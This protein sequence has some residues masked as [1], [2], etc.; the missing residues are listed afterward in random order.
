[1]VSP[2]EHMKRNRGLVCFWLFLGL[3]LLGVMTTTRVSAHNVEA[4]Y[5]QLMPWKKPHFARVLAMGYAELGHDLDVSHAEMQTIAGNSC[6]VGNMVAFEVDRQYAYDIDEPVDLTITYAPEFTTSPLVVLWNKNGGLGRGEMRINPEPGAAMRRVTVTLDRA[7]F[8]KF[9]T[10]GVDIAIE[11]PDDKVG[12][13]PDGKVALCDIE[14]SRSG[15]TKSPSAFGSVHLDVKDAATGK[16]VPARVGLYDATGR[17]PMPS[18]R[19]LLVERFADRVRLLTVD[20]RAF[21]P[22][23]SRVAFYVKGSYE[24]KLPTGTY[25][26]IVTRGPEF[27]VYHSHFD[28][29]EGQAT[30]VSVALER[31]ANLPSR[32]WFSGDDHIHLARDEN[33][34]TTVWTQVAAEDVHVGNLLQM[35]NIKGTYF[36]QPAWGKAGRFEQ[37][38]Y[39]IASGQEDPRTGH[40]GHTI[41]H[42]LQHPI[43]LSQDTYFLYDRAFDESHRQGGIS[44]YAHLNAGWFNVRRGLA[45]D[46]PF[47]KV[48]FLEIFQAGKLLT[49][50]WYDFLNLGYKLTPSA[51]SDFPYT[52]LPGVVRDYVKVDGSND[53][54]AWYASFRAGHVYVTNG[55]F[56]E[57][58]VNGHQMGNEVH[59]AR[60]SRL[61][62]VAQAQLNPDVDKLDRME[63]VVLGDVVAT[64]S[65]HGQDRVQIDTHLTADHSMWI[66]VRAY[67]A[68]HDEWNTTAAHSAA[69]YVIVDDQPSWKKE[70]VPQLVERER[71]V[72][73][74]IL[75]A[76]LVPSED[77]E[78][79][80]TG[81]MLLEQWPKQLLLL[82]PRVQQAD[83]MYQELLERSQK[84]PQP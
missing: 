10:Q 27:R 78:A 62:I 44:G 31:Y 12:G 6:I 42:N 64:E 3:S 23:D 22:S 80:E 68:R 24:G 66:A 50:A 18:D 16:V 69:V 81:Q 34:D 53:P 5:I 82:K 35:G 70:Q 56:L 61:D 29:R 41:H 48:D 77:L 25:E 49:D 75:T 43:H 33:R 73:Q 65:A 37:D 57:F 60:G 21:W 59:V 84:A 45:L 2:R 55:P 71:N 11:S 20:P 83:A 7:R 38:G 40:L 67:G 19:A 13:I 15:K 63:L 58:S 39:L 9:G 32:G 79:F 17:A 76:P 46:I 51:G 26:L 28:V 8:A 4:R 47:G 72:L 54:D 74:E 52:D 1:M 14:I 30:K 36:E